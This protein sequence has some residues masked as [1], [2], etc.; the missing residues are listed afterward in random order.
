MIASHLF[1]FLQNFT[2]YAL[3]FVEQTKF[4]VI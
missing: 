3:N 1:S 4:D 2:F